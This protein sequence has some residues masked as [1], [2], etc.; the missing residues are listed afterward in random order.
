MKI[1]YGCKLI[2]NALIMAENDLEKLNEFLW[3]TDTE[4]LMSEYLERLVILNVCCEI[5]QL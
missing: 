2:M 5:P 1:N 4:I 3:F